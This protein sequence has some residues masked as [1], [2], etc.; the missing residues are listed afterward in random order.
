M[1]VIKK[2]AGK[3]EDEPISTGSYLRQIGLFFFF[4]GCAGISII[5]WI[6]NW[7]CWLNQCCCCDFLHNP[8]NKRIA[9]WICFSF[10]LGILACCISG[11]VI[12][13]RF[14]FAL[15]GARCAFD[16][17]YYDAL[18]GQ[19]KINQP[20]WEG[21]TETKNMSLAEFKRLNEF[22]SASFTKCI[23]EDKDECICGYQC[24]IKDDII[25][26]AQATD[27]TVYI[28]K[29]LFR[30][31]KSVVNKFIINDILP[32]LASEGEIICGDEYIKQAQIPV[33]MWYTHPKELEESIEKLLLKHLTEISALL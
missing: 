5:V 22:G 3:S 12:V 9:W 23:I 8:V 21:Y 32:S 11:F 29:K 27:S 10:L 2:D 20:R 13:N 25:V 7:I 17:I 4:V 31:P 33:Y 19:L 26:Y 14:G 6:F 30:D 1:T 28:S 24:I 18:N 15:E 16:R